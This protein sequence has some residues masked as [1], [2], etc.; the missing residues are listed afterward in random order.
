MELVLECKHYTTSN[1]LAIVCREKGVIVNY[2][3]E[4]SALR[5]AYVGPARCSNELCS[6]L[7]DVMDSC[8][9]DVKLALYDVK[10]EPKSAVESVT[11]PVAIRRVGE[12]T[13]YTAKVEGDVLITVFRDG[14]LLSTA[15]FVEPDGDLTA[16]GAA[17]AKALYERLSF[18]G[19]VEYAAELLG[20]PSL[21]G[22]IAK[23]VREELTRIEIKFPLP[24]L[25]VGPSLTPDAAKLKYDV[26]DW[27]K[28]FGVEREMGY[29]VIKLPMLCRLYE[30]LLK[31]G[32][33]HAYLC[34]TN[35][36]SRQPHNA[37]AER[38]GVYLTAEPLLFSAYVDTNGALCVGERDACVEAM[39]KM[40][41]LALRIY[42]R[43]LKS[44]VLAVYEGRGAVG[45]RLSTHRWD[46]AYMPGLA[47]IA[48]DNKWPTR[49]IG[50]GD[51][52][53]SLLSECNSDKLAT[54][55]ALA[56]PYGVKIPENL[57]SP[58]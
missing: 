57:Y 6:L 25:G 16:A 14:E 51:F 3:K 31:D 35:G 11:V 56:A 32:V 19:A 1:Y 17:V 12:Y 48:R 28:R 36:Y 42:P 15:K 54:A 22:A 10:R 44:G 41:E 45:Y 27:L 40:R 26:E 7:V 4:G 47:A 13:S 2:V 53:Y 52:I 39:L 49:V 33:G 9:S 24:P 50:V 5:C 43:G 18:E 8:E 38:G 55:K 21:K 37:V 20:D 23:R 29:T 34:T 30:Y 46:F 58:S